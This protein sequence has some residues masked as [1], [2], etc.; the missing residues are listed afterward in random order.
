MLSV[1]LLVFQE[2][3][4]AGDVPKVRQAVLTMSFSDPQG[5]FNECP[6]Y[7]A[8]YKALR[9]LSARSVDVVRVEEVLASVA[10]LVVRP[11]AE[12]FQE[13]VQILKREFADL[14]KEWFVANEAMGE[15]NAKLAEDVGKLREELLKASRFMGITMPNLASSTPP[16][17]ELHRVAL[18]RHVVPK[19]REVN[20]QFM[21]LTSDRDRALKQRDQ[22]RNDV[23]ELVLSRRQI[24]VENEE[25][26]EE[27]CKMQGDLDEAHLALASAR[28]E[29]DE[30]RNQYNRLCEALIEEGIDPARILRRL[31]KRPL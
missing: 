15:I 22:A 1:C 13:D 5:L 19:L 9:A 25:L 3:V 11:R 14:Q 26:A 30:A 17:W 28:S 24:E 21:S 2:Q 18:T 27:V 16:F 8:F 23:E 29:A 10:E 4:A 31:E 6:L 12:K 7:V 20:A